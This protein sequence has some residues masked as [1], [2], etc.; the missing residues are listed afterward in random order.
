MSSLGLPNPSVCSWIR[1]LPSRGALWLTATSVNPI[2][3]QIAAEFGVP[4]GFGRWLIAA[5]VPT[6][7]AILLLPI[8]VRRLFPP[9]VSETPDAPRAARAA[10][11]SAGSMTR[12][13]VITAVAFA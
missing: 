4:I 10:L 6:L 3:A 1:G 8:V 12:D 7:A 13:E 5:S 9:G 2:G 11:A